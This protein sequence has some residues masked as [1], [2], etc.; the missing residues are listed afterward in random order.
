MSSGGGEQIE[1]RLDDI[2]DFATR[3]WSLETDERE[4][5][6]EIRPATPD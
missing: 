3:R 6:S 4:A 1:G 2:V 5:L